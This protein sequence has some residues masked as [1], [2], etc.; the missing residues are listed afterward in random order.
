MG[1]LER[2]VVIESGKREKRKVE[3]LEMSVNTPNDKKQ[4]HIPEGTGEKLGDCPRSK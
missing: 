4:L 1:L 3:R 2:P